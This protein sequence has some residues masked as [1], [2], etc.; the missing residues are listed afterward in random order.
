MTSSDVCFTF[1]NITSKK[2]DHYVTSVGA[3]YG[4]KVIFIVSEIN[5]PSIKGNTC[6][7]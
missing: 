1:N 7:K 5:H 3:K 2:A 6:I 4:L